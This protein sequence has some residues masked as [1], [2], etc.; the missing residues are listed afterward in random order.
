MQIVVSDGLNADGVNENLP[1]V[2]QAL[3]RGL[4]STEWRPGEVDVVIENGRVRAGYH[5]GAL[6]DPEI[7]IHF[8]GERPG[9][10]LDTLS[11][12]LTYGRD[13]QGRSRW[14]PDLDHSA[15][16]AICGIHR[17]GKPPEPAAE[18][19]VRTVAR[20]IAERRSGVALAG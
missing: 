17:R 16:T 20:M 11:A 9:T 12:Y 2:L 5:V 19:I 4:D 10:G 7:V 15:T 14:R 1:A 8:I 18:E 3:R 13:P 6:L